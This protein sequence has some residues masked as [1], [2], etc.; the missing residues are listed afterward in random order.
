MNGDES[1]A[2]I[3]VRKN[4]LPALTDPVTGLGSGVFSGLVNTAALASDDAAVLDDL[5]AETFRALAVETPD[6]LS[7]PLADLQQLQPAILR[8]VLAR[9]VQYIGAHE[10]TSERGRA[11]RPQTIAHGS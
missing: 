2:R 11:R 6:Q 5:A 1:V 8:R 4:L 9:A 10:P 3:R 7:F